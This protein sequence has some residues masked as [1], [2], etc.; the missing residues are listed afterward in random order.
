[1]YARVVASQVKPGKLSAI[2][3]LYQDEIVPIIESQPGFNQLLVLSDPETNREISISIWA[4]EADMLAFSSNELPKLMDKFSTLLAAPPMVE[5]Y[6]VCCRAEAHDI[7]HKTR[8]GEVSLGLHIGDPLDIN[9]AGL[10]PELPGAQPHPS[11]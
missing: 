4:K 5:I 11:D 3:R 1:M 8:F 6:R 7:P 9:P 2:T 10:E